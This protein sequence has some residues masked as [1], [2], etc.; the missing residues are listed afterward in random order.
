MIEEK[1]LLIFIQIQK[2][3]LVQAFT[4]RN[5]DAAGLKADSLRR[6]ASLSHTQRR[7]AGETSTG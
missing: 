2:R 4:H 6:I 7:R 3:L 1:T 5:L